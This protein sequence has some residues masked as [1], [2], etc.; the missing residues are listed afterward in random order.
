MIK[1][2]SELFKKEL[3]LI[4]NEALRKI[5]KEILD[6]EVH[7]DNFLKASSSSGKYHPP[8]DNVMYGN[9]NHTKAVFK[10][11]HTL[12]NSRKDLSNFWVDIIYSS[13]ILHDMWK[14]DGTSVHTRNNHAE[15]AY[16]FIQQYRNTDV[17]DE[18]V[19]IQLDYIAYCILFHMG[20]WSFEENEWINKLNAVTEMNLRDSIL[21]LHYADMIASRNFYDIKEFAL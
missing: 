15:I 18:E 1:V 11:C 21:I 16:D 12:L 4:K 13:A 3:N 19:Q 10:L 8:F 6:N 9:T 17:Q 20:H 14:Y 2:G 5:V 7:Y